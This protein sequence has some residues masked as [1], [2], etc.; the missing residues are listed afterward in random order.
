MR[1][2]VAAASRDRHHRDH[3]AA[4]LLLWPPAARAPALLGG[5]VGGA[6]TNRRLPPV[7][8]RPLSYAVR[9]TGPRGGHLS[10][11]LSLL[12]VYLLKT[13][14]PGTV[15]R[16]WGWHLPAPQCPLLML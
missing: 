13:F 16:E 12:V 6:V 1:A 7:Q 2:A 5:E 10:P 9:C 8:T 4:P 3:P 11:A 14:E 15:S